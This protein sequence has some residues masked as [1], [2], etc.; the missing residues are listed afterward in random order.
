MELQWASLLY[1]LA[2]HEK[3]HEAASSLTRADKKYE[4]LAQTGPDAEIYAAWGELHLLW[5]EHAGFKTSA[6]KK[7][8]S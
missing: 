4:M 3:G 1:Q 7:V 5:A 8:L 6:A 2:K